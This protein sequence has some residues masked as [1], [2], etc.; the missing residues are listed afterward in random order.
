MRCKCWTSAT[1]ATDCPIHSPYK[2]KDN[3]PDANEQSV[4]MA[5]AGVLSFPVDGSSVSNNCHSDDSSV[6]DVAPDAE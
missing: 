5:G 1:P 2:E 4:D 6:A 3:G